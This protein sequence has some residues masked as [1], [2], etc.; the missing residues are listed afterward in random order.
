MRF[1]DR[2]IQ[3]VIALLVAFVVVWA[4][5]HVFGVHFP[6]TVAHSYSV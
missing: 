3:A 2:A 1:R 4:L 6:T 5:G